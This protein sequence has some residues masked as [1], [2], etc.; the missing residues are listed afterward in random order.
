M[1][2]EPTAAVLETGG[3]LP[4]RRGWTIVGALSIT[5]TIGYGALYYSFSVLL[6]P[7]SRDLG[8]TAPQIAAALTVSVLAGALCAPLVGRVLDV[9][10]GRGVMTAGA[11]LGTLAL[12]AW[13]QVSGLP[14]LYAV[15]LLLGVA[16]A[17][18]LYEPA[19]AV[20]VSWFDA[21]TRANALL[22]VT[23]VAG[24]ASSIFLPLTGLLVSSFDWRPALI[25]LAVVYGLTAVPLHALVLRRGHLHKDRPAERAA[26]T[27]EAVRS[28]P[29]WLL[30]AAF[31]THG[32]AVAVIG[33]LLVTYLI[34]LGHPPVF[35]A[36]VAGLLGVLSVTGRVVTTGLRRRWAAAPIAGAVF[37][38]QAVGAAL[39]PLVGH[40][41]AGAIGCV[42][43]FGI[44]FGVGTITRPHL[45]AER[46][47]T[48]AYATIAGRIAFFSIGAKA[49]APLAAFAGAEAAGYTVILSTVS[50]LCG[51]AALSLFGYARL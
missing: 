42:L 40:T 2:D 4:V 3:G 44:G 15:F 18:V 21:S 16:S 49:V 8:A 11:A 28:R 1:S 17:M 31:T 22:A 34:H 36:T 43:L 35:A 39:L 12:L 45:L 5:Q 29:F 37:A 26:T 50:V 9:H 6:V 19:F 33:V 32:G 51:I 7:M 24:F 27:R 14:Q 47:G 38:V 10:G 23:I 41:V 25:I 30:V 48:T 20:I 13:S 46:Y